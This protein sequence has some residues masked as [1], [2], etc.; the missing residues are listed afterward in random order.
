MPAGG[1]GLRWRLSRGCVA[2]G[3]HN[4]A[5]ATRYHARTATRT[6]ATLGLTP[7][8]PKRTLSHYAG[9]LAFGEES[10]PFGNPIRDVDGRDAVDRW[11][12]P[13]SCRNTSRR[14]GSPA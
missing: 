14:T 5:A 10:E 13:G 9:A 3:H 12:L 11:S 7:V 2:P 6:L 1:F 4:V 8:S